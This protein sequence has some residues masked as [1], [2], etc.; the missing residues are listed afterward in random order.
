MRAFGRHLAFYAAV[1][2]AAAAFPVAWWLIPKLAIT[3]S[4]NIFFMV[5]LVLT[6]IKIPRLS[7]EFLKRHAARADEP[8]AVIFGVTLLAVAVAVGSLFVLINGSQAPGR[9]PLTLSLMSVALAWATVHTMSSMHY[10]HLYWG[11][12]GDASRGLD[13]P[14]EGEPCGYDFLYFGFVT[15]MTAQT[16]DVSITTTGMRKFNLMHAVVSYFFNTVLVAAAVNLVVSL[17]SS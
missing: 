7:A 9:I 12:Q 17:T 13:F 15:G 4:A 2:C 6:A 10:A 1:L 8:V 11:D 5:Y 16:S 14:G 3:V